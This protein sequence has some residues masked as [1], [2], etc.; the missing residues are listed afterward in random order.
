[1]IMVTVSE[2]K[3]KLSSLIDS[4]EKGEEVLIMRGSRPA[5]TL[6]TV[7]ANDLSFHPDFS[8]RTLAAFESEI[9]A[10]RKAGKLVKLGRDSREASQTLRKLG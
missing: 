3:S 6:V 9:A 1:M 4:A 7:T 10:E 5:V 2:A 8:D